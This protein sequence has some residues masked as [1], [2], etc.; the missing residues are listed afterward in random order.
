MNQRTNGQKNGQTDGGT[1][2]RAHEQKKDQA[3]GRTDWLQRM[4]DG[5]KKEGRMKGKTGGVGQYIYSWGQGH[6]P[7]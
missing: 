6:R 2:K 4:G 7:C 1:N 5:R 3:V